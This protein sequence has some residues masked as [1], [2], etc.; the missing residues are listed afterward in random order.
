MPKSKMVEAL[1]TIQAPM[2]ALLKLTGFK[3]SGRT[4]NRATEGGLVQ[5][6]NFQMGQFP[7]GEYVIPGIRESFYGRFCVNLGVFLPCIPEIEHGRPRPK[8]IHEYDCEVRGRLGALA[9]KQQDVWWELDN[10]VAQTG[11]T[12]AR[13]MDEVGLP[14]LEEFESYDAVLEHLDQRGCLPSSNPGR[15]ALAGAMICSHLGRADD[16]KRYFDLAEAAA[17]EA[18]QSGFRS[19]V[20]AVRSSSGL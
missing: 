8:T 16:A 14:F 12:V 3:K 10:Q 5:V 17:V 7:I 1:D 6:V 4:Y 2:T 11:A 19:H 13:L 9:F 18:R 20:A 15:G